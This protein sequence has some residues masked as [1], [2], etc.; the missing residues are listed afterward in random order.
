MQNMQGCEFSPAF[1]RLNVGLD[2][3]ICCVVYE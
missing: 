2:V 1:S 3:L